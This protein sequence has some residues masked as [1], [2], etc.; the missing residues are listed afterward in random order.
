MSATLEYHAI[1]A[2]KTVFGDLYCINV[3]TL[4]SRTIPRNTLPE[5]ARA[6]CQ[7]KPEF[8][9]FHFLVIN[10]FL[11]KPYQRKYWHLLTQRNGTKNNNKTLTEKAIKVKHGEIFAMRQLWLLH[12]SPELRAN[13]L[14]F[15]GRSKLQFVV[16]LKTSTHRKVYL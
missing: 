10:L 4:C 8:M 9:P 2:D 7:T 11:N 5:D 3:V 16:K 14:S 13:N 12:W 6:Y 1:T 15:K